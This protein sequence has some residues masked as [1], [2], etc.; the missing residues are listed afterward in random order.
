MLFF[1]AFIVLYGLFPSSLFAVTFDMRFFSLL[2]PLVLLSFVSIFLKR[3][4]IESILLF[5][6]MFLIRE[7][8][9]IFGAAMVAYT[10]IESWKNPLESNKKL[11]RTLSI[12][13]LIW[14]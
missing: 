8:A 3:P 11:F 9:L 10:F 4:T 7:E 5:N 1:L 12:S 6:S 14:A 2:T 13:W